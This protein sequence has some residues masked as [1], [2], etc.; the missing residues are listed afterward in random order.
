MA[1][2]STNLVTRPERKS[3]PNFQRI[4]SPARAF[5]KLVGG[6]I[7]REECGQE[8]DDDKTPE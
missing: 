5:N 6:S 3:G 7:L 8:P 2:R 1:E 4:L